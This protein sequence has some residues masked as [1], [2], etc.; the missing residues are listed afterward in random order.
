MF[1]SSVKNLKDTKSF[2]CMASAGLKKTPQVRLLHRIVCVRA[3]EFRYK[4]S[5]IKFL[6]LR[7][8]ALGIFRF[9]FLFYSGGL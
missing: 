1:G 8:S 2:Y 6:A 7:L 5:L 9:A 4:N 3:K